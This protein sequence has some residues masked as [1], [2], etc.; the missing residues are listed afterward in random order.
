MIAA[1]Q[2]PLDP[3]TLHELH[4]LIE[5]SVLGD[6]VNIRA[7]DLPHFAAARVHVFTRKTPLAHEK[8]DP[9]RSLSLGPGL[10]PSQQVAL[11]HNSYQRTVRVDHR[12]TAELAFQH[13]PDSLHDRRV[14]E[15]VTGFGVMTSAAR[16]APSLCSTCSS[17]ISR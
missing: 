1:P 6:G 15:T 10:G 8:L 4:D 13:Q 14:G 5:W 7:H 11:R 12:K 16:I 2:Q 9:T 3:M 17:S